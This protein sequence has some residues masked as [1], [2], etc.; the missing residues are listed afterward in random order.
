[1]SN[2]IASIRYRCSCSSQVWNNHHWSTPQGNPWTAYEAPHKNPSALS[3]L[4]DLR[5]L[6]NFG[7]ICTLKESI[8]HKH[9]NHVLVQS[10]LSSRSWF[11]KVRVITVWA[12]SSPHLTSIQLLKRPVQVHSEERSSVLYHYSQLS[13]SNLSSRVLQL[14]TH[15]GLLLV[16]W[17]RSKQ[18]WFLDDIW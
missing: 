8:L 14:H 7:I 10:K 18:S 12:S 2:P 3:A 4:V 16:Q 9:A 6:S 13:T 1:M 17:A 5:I 11:V 15:C